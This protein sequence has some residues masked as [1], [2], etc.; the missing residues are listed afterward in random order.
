MKKKQN[1]GLHIF[2]KNNKGMVNGGSSKFT[3]VNLNPIKEHK[4][5]GMWHQ[6]K[7]IGWQNNYMI[8]TSVALM[9]ISVC[10]TWGKLKLTP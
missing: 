4:S 10:K 2:F 5:R 9:T 3:H 6:N 1:E 7:P 8:S